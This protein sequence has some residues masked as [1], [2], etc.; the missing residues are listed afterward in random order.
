MVRAVEAYVEECPR[1]GL[2]RV[3]GGGV[4]VFLRNEV[5]VGEVCRSC[6]ERA[7][8]L[9]RDRRAAWRERWGRLVVPYI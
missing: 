6:A 4:G 9:A 5:V 1:C 7:R 2:R 8:E 3:V